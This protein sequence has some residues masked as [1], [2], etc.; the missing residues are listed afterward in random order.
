MT[1]LTGN[2]SQREDITKLNNDYTNYLHKWPIHALK[3]VK[4]SPLN[5]RERISLGL[6]GTVEQPSVKSAELHEHHQT[7]M[8]VPF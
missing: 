8:T 2:S 7:T 6:F 1:R 3:L 4:K 5:G